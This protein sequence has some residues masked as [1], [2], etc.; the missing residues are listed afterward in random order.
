MR[1]LK[2]PAQR[3]VTVKGGSSSVFATR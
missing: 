2:Q 1:S 3:D